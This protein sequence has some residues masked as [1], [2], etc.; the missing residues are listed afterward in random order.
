MKKELGKALVK[1]YETLKANRVNWVNHWEE[2]ADFAS[3]DRSDVYQSRSP[4]EKRRKST[5][6]LYDAIGENAV[7]TLGSALHS[8]L[9]NPTLF[10]FSLGL[11]D[12]DEE[13]SDPV[14]EW[15]QKTTRIVHH[16]LKGS[17]FQ[18]N[19]SQYYED[20]LTFG[21]G[22]MKVI[23]DDKDVFNFMTKPIYEACIADTNRGVVDTVFR[24]FK[25]DARQIEMEFGREHLPDEVLKDLD[26]DP[27]K[28]HEIIH[29][30]R[31]RKEGVKNS[32]AE[33][34]PFASYYVHT[35]SNEIISEGGFDE[36]P[37][38]VS[39]WTLSSGEV[40][41]RGPVMKALPDIK[42]IN[43]IWESLIRVSQKMINPPVQ[44]P[45][46]GSMGPVN[47]SPGGVTYV[48]PGGDRIE[49]IM[50]PGNIP[51]GVEMIERKTQSIKEMF[52]IDQLKLVENDRM[53]TV[54]VNQRVDEQLRAMSP[55]LS[56]QEH[57]LLRPLIERCLGILGRKG[58]LP[59]RPEEL[60][61][62]AIIP[63]YT[64][65]IARVQ[66]SSEADN[67]LRALGAISPIIESKPEV[68]DFI[69]GDEAIKLAFEAFNVDARMINSDA[70]VEETREARQE[71]QAMMQQQEQAALEADNLSKLVQVA[72]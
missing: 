60:E 52:F 51:V 33:N 72:K 59:E 61:D 6:I 69:N 11:E 16:Y 15:L 26:K 27:Y 41:G 2:A 65:Q 58:L 34:K 39:R 22:F 45:D 35:N 9:T 10:W 36:F 18:Q 23:P 54:E 62:S 25:F 63:K 43:K 66:K 44:V 21:T 53:T 55:I 71:Q 42:L 31:P 13:R 37:Y 38:V 20:L 46:D 57:E 12:E 40:Y 47:L 48:R 30:V 24:C 70:E 67:I 14:R 28:K 29:C 19:I 4:G 3:P 64:S 50:I 1:Q 49:P 17:N 32:P 5:S 7:V 68:F 8:M 56:R